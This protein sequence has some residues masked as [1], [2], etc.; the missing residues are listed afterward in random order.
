MTTLLD[1]LGGTAP[2]GAVVDKFYDIMLA[3][4]VVNHFFKNTDMTKQRSQQKAFLGMAFGGDV[5]YNGKDMKAA[6]KGMNIQQ[7]EFD[8]TWKNLKE[9]LEFYKVKE[10]LIEEVKEVFYSTSG[11]IVGV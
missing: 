11:D 1:K 10:D 8:A 7:K 3:D 2:L 5:E 9:A 6:H 4:P